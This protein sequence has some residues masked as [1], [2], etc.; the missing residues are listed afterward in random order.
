MDQTAG[1]TRDEEGVIDLELDGVLQ[2]LLG[3]LEHAVELLG[4]CDCSWEAVEDEAA[5]RG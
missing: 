5:R 2:G 1:D 3:G 4:L